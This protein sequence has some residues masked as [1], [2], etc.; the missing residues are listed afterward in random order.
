MDI[1][2]K[3][4]CNGTGKRLANDNGSVSFK[5]P[6][7]NDTMIYRSAQARRAVIKYTCSG[8]GFTGPN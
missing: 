6:E 4:V 7:C 8:C 5:C 3:P 1:E 2:Q